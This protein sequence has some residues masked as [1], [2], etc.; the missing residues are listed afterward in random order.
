[1][2]K[3][4]GQHKMKMHEG[5]LKGQNKQQ[6]IYC[7]INTFRNVVEHWK[8]DVLQTAHFADHNDHK[9]FISMHPLKS[10]FTKY[11]R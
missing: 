8:L 4:P 10:V 1:M 9:M 5:P 3:Y 11:F 2:R 6:C 7:I